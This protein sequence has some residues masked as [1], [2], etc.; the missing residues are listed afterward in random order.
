MDALQHSG[1]CHCGALRFGFA[2]RHAPQDFTPRACDCDFCTRHAAA[3]LSDPNGQLR[4][5]GAGAAQRYR[6]GSE[7]AD[8]LLCPRCGVLVAVVIATE[9]GVLGAANRHAFDSRAEV[10]PG[11]TASPQRLSPSEKLA[12][13]MQVWTPVIFD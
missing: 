9:G 6:Q 11:I 8:F 10:P 13:W 2:T 12:R 5:R 4:I 7:Q 1:G 3:W